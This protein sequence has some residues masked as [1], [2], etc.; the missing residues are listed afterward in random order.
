MK[1]VL[2]IALILQLVA[3][4]VTADPKFP[5][6]E[7]SLQAVVV[8]SADWNASTAKMLRFERTSPSKPWTAVGNAVPVNLG[9]TGLAWGRSDLIRD[10]DPSSTMGPRKKEGDG[11]AP[12]GL[13]PFLQAF[14]HPS[15]PTG[16]SDSNLPFLIVEA[17]QCV[18]DAESEHYNTV[19]K[20]S[21]VGGVTWN[22]AETMKIDLYRMGLVVGHNCPDAKPGMGSCI[23]FHLQSKAGAP[24]SGCT[25]M[26][27]ASLTSLLLWLKRDA[28]PVVLQLPQAEFKKR[29]DKSWPN[30]K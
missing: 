24:T 10:S 22:S 2:R 13:F 9:R 28:Q 18:D 11:K 14:G 19:V 1:I 23:F 21:E 20:P 8:L 25:A 27:A 29:H 6:P 26:D 15:S 16:Y 30:W 5:I 17:E 3:L 7:S 12:A 4:A